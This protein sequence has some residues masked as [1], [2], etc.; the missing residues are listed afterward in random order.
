VLHA[1]DRVTAD[2]EHASMREAPR[3]GDGPIRLIA[4]P[5][6]DAQ[7]RILMSAPYRVLPASDRVGTR[8]AGPP[9]LRPADATERSRPMVRGAI[10]LPGDGQ[11]I[12]L[13]PEHPT[14][15][16]YPVVAVIASAD[17]DRFFAVRIGGEVRFQL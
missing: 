16:G 14:T 1:G 17:L 9:V 12:V 3:L 10:E 13:G 2:R 4:T 7:I 5:D 15:G 6:H 11:P 8:L